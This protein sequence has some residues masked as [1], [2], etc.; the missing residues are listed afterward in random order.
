MSQFLPLCVIEMCTEG[1][2]DDVTVLL[3]CVIGMC[4]EESLDYVTLLTL[5]FIEMCTEGIGHDS[6]NREG[7][8]AKM[9][10]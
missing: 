2:P 9:K 3:L 7:T 10:E 4:T 5:C 6:K 8:R 1:S